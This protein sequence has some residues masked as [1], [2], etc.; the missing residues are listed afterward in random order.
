MPVEKCIKLI[1]H[2]LDL[3]NKIVAIM[4]DGDNIIKK[5]RR[6]LAANQQLCFAHGIQLEVEVLYQ[7][8]E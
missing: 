7:K 5:V 6:L 3:R 1:E 8:K 4:T 2:S